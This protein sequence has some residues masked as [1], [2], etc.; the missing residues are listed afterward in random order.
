MRAVGS[1][2]IVVVAAL[3]ALV[4]IASSALAQPP[5][6]EFDRPFID[7]P[8]SGYERSDDIVVLDDE[9]FGSHLLGM[10][11]ADRELT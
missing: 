9:S 8:V 5:E 1:R 6:E 7:E 11:W 3:L 10:I 2:A 4:A